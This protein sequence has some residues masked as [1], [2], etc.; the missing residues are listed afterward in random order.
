MSSARLIIDV[1]ML[2][3]SGMPATG[4]SRVSYELSRWAV[5]NRPGTRLA[6]VDWVYDLGKLRE[7]DSGLAREV[8][9]KTTLIDS[10]LIPDRGRIGKLRIREHLPVSLH[11]G[12]MALQHPRRAAVMQLQR[13]QQRT[14][15]P[16]AARLMSRLQ[17]RMLT[18]K[19]RRELTAPSGERA[20]LV[21]YREA[22]VGFDP[23][24]ND[25][26]ILTG[27]EWGWTSPSI[28]EESESQAR[29]AAG[30]DVLR[31]YPAASS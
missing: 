3:R 31:Y 18:D 1:S 30:L 10:F 6:A 23:R 22:L 9:E 14:K 4:I 5:R 20:R 21:S 19:Y 27:A 26:L 24:P 12:L 11:Y 17:E 2:I 28:Y 7:L 15:V 25:T 16:A 29:N 13:W 8:L